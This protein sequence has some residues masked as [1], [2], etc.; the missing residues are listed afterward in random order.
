MQKY[1]I[2]IEKKK[3]TVLSFF[4]FFL[5][6]CFF[7][8][9][10]KAQQQSKN[11]H[12]GLS[13]GGIGTTTF[14]NVGPWNFDKNKTFMGVTGGAFFR[15]DFAKHFFV[16]GELSVS[17]RRI[18]SKGFSMDTAL[19]NFELSSKYTNIGVPLGIGY[20]F[21]PRGGPLNINILACAVL[22]FP[23]E[24]NINISIHKQNIA[25]NLQQI[26]FGAMLDLGF[27]YKFIS[28]DLRYEY[29]CN[30]IIKI[31]NQKIYTGS[32]SFLVGFHIL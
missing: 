21:F 2:L 18:E 26:T 4:L 15:Y 29:E 10:S 16:H 19:G 22:N 13:I 27:R 5:C 8:F 30:N 6:V 9:S 12:F 20:Y 11:I 32:F 14:P 24:K 3:K 23:Q 1:A 28:L 7:S 25:Q 31:Q 17:M